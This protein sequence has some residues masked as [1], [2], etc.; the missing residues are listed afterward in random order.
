MVSFRFLQSGQ[1]NPSLIRA[2]TLATYP[3]G[4]SAVVADSRLEMQMK[5]MSGLALSISL[6]TVVAAARRAQHGELAHV[7]F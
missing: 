5:K 1:P 7:R 4:L 2:F 3:Y 6:F